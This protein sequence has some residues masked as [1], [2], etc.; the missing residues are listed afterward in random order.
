[1]GCL[2]VC[3]LV[4]HDDSRGNSVG[5]ATIYGPDGPW[6]QS[7]WWKEIFIFSIS[8]LGSTQSH[9]QWVPEFFSGDKAPGA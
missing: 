3:L 2:F 4:S 9:I 7:G 6:L 5:I 8:G 1:M